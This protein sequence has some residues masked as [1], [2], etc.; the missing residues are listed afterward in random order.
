VLFAALHYSPKTSPDASTCLPSFS[1]GLID[2]SFSPGT[3]IRISAENL[4]P[5]ICLSSPSVPRVRMDDQHSFESSGLDDFDGTLH[6]TRYLLISAGSPPHCFFF[7]ATISHPWLM[8]DMK[9]TGKQCARTS[10]TCSV[11]AP[12]LLAFR[13]L[14]GQKSVG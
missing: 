1:S 9:A 11:T 8:L 10:L 3:F 13:V 5:S 2:G 12:A 14:F 4:N 7:A 6:S